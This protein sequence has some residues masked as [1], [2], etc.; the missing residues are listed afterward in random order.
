MACPNCDHTMASLGNDWFHCPRCGVILQNNSDTQNVC[1]PRLVKYTRRMLEL[2]ESG[3][4][5][6]M[7]AEKFEVVVK[8]LRESTGKNDES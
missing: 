8:T 4:L 2:L 7:T 5:A 1:V 6:L 3:Q